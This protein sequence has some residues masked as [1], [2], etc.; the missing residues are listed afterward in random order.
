MSVPAKLYLGFSVRG[1]QPYVFASEFRDK[2]RQ[3]LKAKVVDDYVTRI[4]ASIRDRWA[5]VG[6]LV[7]VAVDAD[8]FATEANIRT[9]IQAELDHYNA[10]RNSG[11]EEISLEFGTSAP[12]NEVHYIHTNDTRVCI[13]TYGILVGDSS[14]TF[15]QNSTDGGG[16][17]IPGGP[18][19][20]V[21]LNLSLT[22]ESP[23]SASAPA[24]GGGG[25]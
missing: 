18:V 19:Q 6:D 12:P 3:S 15:S 7:Q 11:D 1:S 21:V 9:T 10:N 22:F 14:K 4:P 8:G 13:H 23:I 24:S 20:T 25:A 17:A 2:D 16:T 5:G